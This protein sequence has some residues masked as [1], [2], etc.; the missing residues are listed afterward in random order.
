LDVGFTLG[1]NEGIPE[2]DMD[3]LNVG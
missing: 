3:G 1:V 2:G